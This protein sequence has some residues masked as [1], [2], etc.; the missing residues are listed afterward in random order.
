MIQQHVVQRTTVNV[1]ADKTIYFLPMRSFCRAPRRH[2]TMPDC[3]RQRA[4][5]S[6]DELHGL[7]SDAAAPA[8]AAAAAAAATTEI[9]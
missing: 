7:A 3:Q 9:N 1:A 6:R 2:I 4:V 8:A 5:T